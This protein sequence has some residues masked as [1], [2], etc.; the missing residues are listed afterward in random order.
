MSEPNSVHNFDDEDVADPVTLIRTENYQVWSCPML[1]ALEGKN[2]IGF[3]D[4]SCK[5]SNT[6][7]V[8]GRQWD[9]NRSFIADYYNK[10]NALW[11]QYDAMIELPKCVCNA[12]KS[13]KKH[14]QLMKL[15]QFLM[16]LY[17]SY[18]Q[19]R[20]SIISRE[21]LPDVRSAYAT[22]SSEES[23][24]VAY[25]SIIGSSQRNQASAFVSNVP[26]RG[27]VQRGQ[28]SSTA[29]RPNKFNY[30]KQGGG[31]GLVYE[32]NLGKIIMEIMFQ[33]MLLGLDL[34]LHDWHCRLAHPAEIVQNVLKGS[35][36]INN[37]VKNVYSET[38]QRAK[39]TREHFPLIDHVSKSL[40]LNHINFFDC[41]YPEIPNDDARVNPNMN[42]DNKSYSASRNS[43]ESFQFTAEFLVNSKND[44]DSSVDIFATRD[45]GITTLEEND[46][47]A[48][49]SKWIFKIKYQSNGEIDRFKARLVAWGVGQKEGI[50]YEETFSLVVKMV[51]VR[52]LL[53]IVVSNS[54]HVFLLDVNNAFLYGYLD[55]GVFLALLV[56]VDDIMITQNNVYEI[57]KFKVFLKSKFMIK[58]LGK[59]KYFLGIEV[60]DTDK[61]LGIDIVKTSGM[62]LNAYSDVDWAKCVITRKSVIG[63]CV[64]LNDSLVSWKNKKYNILSKS[65]TQAQYRAL[66]QL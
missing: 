31:S 11:K 61:G 30:N 27:V 5:R 53:N 43:S 50:D 41:E 56:Y 12:S 42:S 17:D 49:G 3:I 14:N 28:S 60:V 62:F 47:N 6:D 29:I 16:G 64:F 37:K 40:D 65:S 33:I 26:N 35:L 38:C 21:V 18:M 39:Q 10:L 8:L 32:K 13:F 63:Y 57:E 36:Q 24:R 59:P 54:W 48:I 25:G 58:D 2:K 66:V 1:L 15:M 20:S 4:G 52:C 44:A 51:I 46:R 34:L 45:E 23:H 9:R 19:I 22:I 7:E 55:E